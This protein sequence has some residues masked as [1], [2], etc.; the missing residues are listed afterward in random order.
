[1]RDRALYQTMASDTTR[2]SCSSRR[3]AWWEFDGQPLPKDGGGVCIRRMQTP[4][5]DS[6]AVPLLHRGAVLLEP[7]GQRR[8][9]RRRVARPPTDAMRF[10]WHTYEDRLDT[11]HLERLVVL[12][13]LRHRRA[14]VFLP[15]HDQR[16][17]LH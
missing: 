10:L 17:R 9:L 13:R 8:E 4:P 11:A 6:S 2:R 1:M 7:A 3:R 5:L 12:L 16:G 15:R 14:E